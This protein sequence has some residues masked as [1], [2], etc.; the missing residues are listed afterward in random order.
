MPTTADRLRKQVDKI[1]P[2]ANEVRK[3]SLRAEELLTQIEGRE[4]RERQRS[5]TRATRSV[6]TSTALQ[7]E[8]ARR[9]GDD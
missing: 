5:R 8:M 3:H 9:M 4:A 1:S 6:S 2:V 7:N